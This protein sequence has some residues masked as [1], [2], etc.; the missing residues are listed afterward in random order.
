VDSVDLGKIELSD[1]RLERHRVIINDD[2]TIPIEKVQA[3]EFTIHNEDGTYGLWSPKD[4]VELIGFIKLY[5]HFLEMGN[6]LSLTN[7]HCP[8]ET[9]QLLKA[10]YHASDEGYLV[11][12]GTELGQGTLALLIGARL[13]G[14][15][16]PVIT[17]DYD[18]GQFSW[19][20]WQGT[21]RM[22]YFLNTIRQYGFIE[23]VHSILGNSPIVAKILNIPISLLFIDGEHSEDGVTKDILAFKDKIISKGMIYCH[24]YNTEYYPYV[25]SVVNDLIRDSQ[26]F[27]DFEPLGAEEIV[28]LGSRPLTTLVRAERLPHSE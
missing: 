26:D 16:K 18:W 21:D 22:H 10:A 19:G 12:T 15:T 6:P 17:I 25:T 9:H 4:L 24:D 2:L 28:T 20:G 27:C 7:N 3:L 14:K 11:E 5:S 23:N 8:Y 1:E 13:S